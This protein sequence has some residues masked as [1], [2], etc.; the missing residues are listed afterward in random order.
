[1]ADPTPVSA[2][3]ERSALNPMRRGTAA[4]AASILGI[5]TTQVYRLMDEG[6]IESFR[7][8]GRRVIVWESVVRLLPE[9][10]AS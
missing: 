3:P 6:V 5:S 2:L 8:G 4:E 9:G 10:S 1:M 7:V